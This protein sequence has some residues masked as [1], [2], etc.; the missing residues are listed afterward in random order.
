MREKFLS[1]LRKAKDTLSGNEL[2]SVLLSLMSRLN[3]PSIVSEDIVLDLLLSFRDLQKYDMMVGLVENLEQQPNVKF[4]M[5][6]TILEVYTFALNRR[7]RPGDREKA[8]HVAKSYCDDTSRKE[9]HT[10]DL[11]CMCGRIYKDM[12]IDSDY[13]ENDK[14]DNS[15]QW[16]RRSF[17]LHQTEHAG[18][19]LATMLVVA[20]NDFKTCEELKHIGVILNQKIGRK[21]ILT[22]LT[23]YW[24]VATFFELNVLAENYT[25]AIQ[26]AECMFTLRPPDWA[27]KTTMRNIKLINRFRHKPED[28]ILSPEEQIYWFWMEFFV[29]AAYD[30]QD[31]ANTIRFPMLVLEANKQYMPT[32]TLVNK[33]AEQSSLQISNTCIDCLKDNN[34]RLIHEWNVETSE[35]RGL[36]LYKR[37]ERCLFLY[38]HRNSD[39]FQMFFP[40]EK[41]RRR[42]YD[43]LL[44]MSQELKVTS[45]D[46][47]D[48]TQLEYEY[49]LDENG[50]KVLL[51]KGTYGAVYSARD[52]RRQTMLAV[53]EIHIRNNDEVQPLREEIKLHSQLNH[54]NIVQYL[55]SVCEDDTFKIVMERVPGGSLTSLIHSKWGA[56]KEETIVFYTRQI[57]QGLKYLHDQNIV[58]RD[59]KGENV[60][61]NNYTG[62]LKIS[63]FG[64]SRRLAGLNPKS[65]KFIGT[66]HFMAPEVIDQ[67]PRGYGPPAD[68]WSL[69]C[70]IVEMAT[71]KTPFEDLSGPMV[72]Y[73]IGQ[74]KAHPDIPDHLSEKAR[75]FILRCFEIEPSKRATAG[76][77]LE[78]PF[79]AEGHSRKKKGTSAT[80]PPTPSSLRVP[81]PLDFARSISLPAEPPP[82]TSATSSPE[83]SRV[84]SD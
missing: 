56:L 3:D 10:P 7:G 27:I 26:C 32:F 59:I 45:F 39:D 5:T 69:G 47:V 74:N 62:T 34:C 19:N 15:I 76:E 42:F 43:L 38:V 50:H 70:T 9:Y 36:A 24:M 23:D 33:D 58:H 54:K 72:L 48:E 81:H 4:A 21:G 80:T 64:T 66:F 68:I 67:G 40:S 17:E 2:Y 6:P 52:V 8:L 46:D 29:S 25:K 41:L 18:I 57:L 53:K 84:Q 61:V 14:R 28:A 73:T 77:L 16:Y 12:F 37:D 31:I 22:S 30:E 13:S 1:D 49:E 20:G 71:G 79:I 11:L 78:D 75:R 51:G 35:L 65:E 44:E 83:D 60:L 82:P 63:D 55:G